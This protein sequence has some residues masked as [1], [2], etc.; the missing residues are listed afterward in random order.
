MAAA[1][2]LEG[3]NAVILDLDTVG[4]VNIGGNEGKSMWR[5]NVSDL[6]RCELRDKQVSIGVHLA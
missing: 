2:V 4:S 1:E 5:E 6:P 3:G